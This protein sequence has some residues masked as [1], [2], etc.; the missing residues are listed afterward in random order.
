MTPA[1]LV[2]AAA[3]GSA[4]ALILGLVLRT[5]LTRAR[6]LR[7]HV[8]AVTLASLAAGALVAYVLSVQ[9][10]VAPE[11]ARTVLVVLALTSCFA[12]I[13]V[14][15]AS[16]PLGR[17]VRRLERTVRRLEAG[18]R[19]VRTEVRRG[20]ELGHVARALDDA[21]ERLDGLER[22]RV[23]DE[24]ARNTMFSSISHD[25]RTPL[26]ALRAALEAMEDGITPDP[27]RYLRSM[28][29]DIEALTSLVDDLFL[30]TRIESGSL[31]VARSTV[32]LTE[33]ADEAIEALAPVAEARSVRLALEAGDRVLV[34][35]NA[36]ALGRVVRNLV[37]NAV[38]HSPVRSV[39][40][41][42]IEPGHRPI[43]RVRDEGVG[44]PQRFEARAF[45]RFTRADP[46]RSRATGGAGLGLAIAHGLVRAHGGDIWIDDV[47]HGSVSFALPGS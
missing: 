47:P 24:D 8:L 1:D 36:V 40:T 43:V 18:D 17:D 29:R 32:D 26:S 44:F 9:M 14:I 12:A 22:Q 11:E 15:T 42:V 21:I 10:V 37:D 23:A 27:A 39:V 25:L 19:T 4:A 33:I 20:D 35:G 38:R 16:A 2:W 28:Q 45:D 41:V 34:Q 13:L 31:E 30:L 46:S 7:R 3:A 6:S 5:W